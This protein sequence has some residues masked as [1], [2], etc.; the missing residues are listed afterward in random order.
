MLVFLTEAERRI[1]L[2]T[3]EAR[4]NGSRALGCR[5]RFGACDPNGTRNRMG[6]CGELAVAKTLG[7]PMSLSVNTFKEEPDF[8]YYGIPLEVRT[9]EWDG[10]PLFFR[11]G[12]NPEAVFVHVVQ[13]EAECRFRINGWA[14]GHEIRDFGELSGDPSRPRFPALKKNQLKPL[15]DLLHVAT[16]Y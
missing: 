11:K 1:A 15:L 5:D 4:E 10:T 12:D 7:L 14:Y 8:W 16:T 13:V 2:M 3:A 6:C 9:S